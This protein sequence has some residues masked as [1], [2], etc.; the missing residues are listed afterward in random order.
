MNMLLLILAILLSIPVIAELVSIVLRHGKSL[1]RIVKTTT[2]EA[3]K[4]GIIS[5]LGLLVGMSL[6]YDASKSQEMHE[7]HL[8]IVEESNENVLTVATETRKIYNMPN[9]NATVLSTLEYKYNLTTTPVVTNL[10]KVQ[11]QNVS[12]ETRCMSF[13]KDPIIRVS[14]NIDRDRSSGMDPPKLI[15]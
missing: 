10:K 7:E 14:F 5:F 4:W 13:K 11:V 8:A 9:N 12:N 15:T 3:D 1:S 2:E 6:N